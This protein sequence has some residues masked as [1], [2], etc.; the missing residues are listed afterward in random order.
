V[1]QPGDTNTRADRKAVCSFAEF[2]D[3]ADDLVARNNW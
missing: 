1:V 2:L 3:N